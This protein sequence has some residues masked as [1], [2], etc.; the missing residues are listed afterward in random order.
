[1]A[2]PTWLTRTTDL[3]LVRREGK[4]FRSSMLEV[5]SLASLLPSADEQRSSRIGV[6]VP[7]YQHSAVDRNRVKR[8]LRAALRALWPGAFAAGA[9][10]AATDVVVRAAPSA[11]RADYAT[12]A[13]DLAKL[14]AR[15]GTA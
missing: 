9:T 5:R 2:S 14:L 4:R 6:I 15:R 13:A 11:Y 8:R 3:E 7:R 12:L 1:V 10:G